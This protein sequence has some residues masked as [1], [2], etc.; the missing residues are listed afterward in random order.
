MTIFFATVQIYQVF[1]LLL[2][3]Y[4][5]DFVLLQ[6]DYM[7]RGKSKSM[8]PLLL[9]IGVYSL[10][11][12]VCTWFL[13]SNGL[14]MLLFV[15]INGLSHLVIDYFT[16]RQS[17]KLFAQGKAGSDSIPNFGAFSVIG[18][19]QLL[20]TFILIASFAFLSGI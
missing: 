3:H 13:F 14:L 17:S 11:L 15:L 12:M 16:S 1:W 18:F 8:N 7:A 20:H 9:H 4:I 19:D 5:S 6:T 2:A 10:S